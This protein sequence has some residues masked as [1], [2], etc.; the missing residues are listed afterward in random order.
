MADPGARW[1]VLGAGAIGTLLAH[2]L[3]EAGV[4]V[5][6]LRRDGPAGPF[7]HR[8]RDA[9]GERERVFAARPAR[10]PGVVER[11]LVTLKTP[12]LADAVAAIA[13]H[14]AATAP[15]VL[16][17]NGCGYGAAVAARLPGRTLARGVTSDGAYRESATLTVHAGRGAT[18][19]GIPARRRA[20]PPWFSD[21][22]GRPA[23]LR[24]LADID[25]AL[26]R[27]LAVNCAVNGLCAVHGCRNG[28]LL[29]RA[30]LRR[31]LDALVAE[32]AAALR[33]LGQG[34]SAHGLG[35]RVQQVLTATATN[36]SSMLEDVLAGR[37]TEIESLN[38]YL[39]RR[40]AA[41]GLTL[42]RNQRLLA[43]VRAASG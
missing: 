8:L 6:L 24:W 40:A 33:A 43:R 7:R 17:A 23:Q 5:V 34:R 41:V 30:D 12:A 25:T 21:S 36:R 35:A 37:E 27:K 18:A 32:I 38:G 2:R 16:L 15:V 39:C 28:Q 20:P 42:P 11:L 19:L 13:P 3:A 14:V 4:E 29:A 10:D 22:L 9:G 26:W 1:H 31:Q